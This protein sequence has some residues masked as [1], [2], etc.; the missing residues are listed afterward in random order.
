MDP[1]SR[2]R[3]CLAL[4]LFMVGCASLAGGQNGLGPMIAVTG[5]LPTD[6][7]GV[8]VA[9][10]GDVDGDGVGD[11]L[12]GAWQQTISGTG[13]VVVISGATRAPLYTLYGAAAADM[14]GGA[15]ARVGDVDLDGRD[16]FIVGAIGAGPVGTSAVWSGSAFLVSGA[17]GT[18]LFT[19][20]LAFLGDHNG[21]AV[22]G[23]G[24][25]TGDGMPDFAVSGP[26]TPVGY[27]P[28]TPAPIPGRVRIFD[29]VAWNLVS[30]LSDNFPGSQFGDCV[31]AVGDLD[32]DNVQEIAIGAPFGG[33]LIGTV[34]SGAVYVY[35]GATSALL[36]TLTSPSIYFTQIGRSVAGLGDVDGDQVPDIAVLASGTV[37]VGTASAGAG[38]VLVYSGATGVLLWSKAG[39]GALSVAGPGDV[40]GDGTRD[41]AVGVFQVSPPVPVYPGAVTFFDGLV[42]MQLGR[43]TAS[44]PQAYF[45]FSLDAAGDA[46]GDGLGD[47]VVGAPDTTPGTGLNMAGGVYTVGLGGAGAYGPYS[48]PLQ[49][50]ILKWTPIAGQLGF[51]E[52]AA[53]TPSSATGSLFASFGRAQIP[54]PAGGTALVD[55]AQL[56][57]G[58]P[59]PYSLGLNGNALLALVDLH[60]P[61]LA[62]TRLYLQCAELYPAG[63][64]PYRI[65]NGLELSFL[66]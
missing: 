27:V 35:S 31:R 30:Q 59:L 36:R 8:S 40:N 55:P 60:M 44:A 4:A 28:V 37:P 63:T 42:G 1:N 48:L 10:L 38:S 15:V 20:A 12:A 9:R 61:G 25:V 58:I 6:R 17:T 5:T 24:D 13:Y 65:S 22:A 51:V 14:F 62:G 64:T 18:I 29:G 46:A 50:L 47:V 32:G 57:P 66:P 19:V 16:D 21:A 34:G 49:S 33:P 53:G 41:V 45:G 52:I 43:F 56:L 23:V 54:L 39:I 3:S 7:L 2:R 26:G 11:F